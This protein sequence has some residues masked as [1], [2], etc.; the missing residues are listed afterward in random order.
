MMT[1]SV[2]S[3]TSASPA[4]TASPS[5]LSHAPTVASTTDSPSVG[6]RTS[7]GIGWHPFQDLGNNAALLGRMRRGP[8]FSR[9]GAHG[10]TDVAQRALAN[11]LAQMSL[12]KRPGAHI[13]RLF[14]KP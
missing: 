11:Q 6:T 5:R 9:T 13:A 10:A 4:S 2:S 1:F 12:D 8:A 7:T 3:W 14:L